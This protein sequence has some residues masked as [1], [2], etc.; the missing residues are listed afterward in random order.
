MLRIY[1]KLPSCE[2]ERNSSKSW[3]GKKTISINYYKEKKTQ[4]DRKMR[5]FTESCVDQWLLDLQIRITSCEKGSYLK[6]AKYRLTP[7]GFRK[8]KFW[9]SKQLNSRYLYNEL[10]FSHWRCWNIH[11]NLHKRSSLGTSCLKMF[12][13]FLK[14]QLAEVFCF[15]LTMKKQLKDMPL[16]PCPCPCRLDNE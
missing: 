5:V 4:K 2:A 15:A 6:R 13:E 14:S 3:I 12:L 10:Y 8:S 7:E 1:T 9:P 11:C 16:H